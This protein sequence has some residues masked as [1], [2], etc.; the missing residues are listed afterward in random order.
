[1]SIVYQMI[2]DHLVNIFR[3]LIVMLCT[4][5]LVLLIDTHTVDKVLIKAINVEIFLFPINKY[6]AKFAKGYF[7]LQSLIN[8][9][10]LN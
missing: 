6:Q 8:L 7:T 9:N 1:M 2:L 3:T 4:E 10:F 5:S